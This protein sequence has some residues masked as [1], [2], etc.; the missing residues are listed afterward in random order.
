MKNVGAI[1]IARTSKK[2]LKKRGVIKMIKNKNIIYKA[3]SILFV[4]IFAFAVI[5]TKDEKSSVVTNAEILSNIKKELL[6][7]TIGREH[8]N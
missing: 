3:L 7:Q 5:K 2:L 4:L 8:R 1:L 6:D